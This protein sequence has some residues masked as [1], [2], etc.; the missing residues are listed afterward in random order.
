M[1]GSVIVFIEAYLLLN[2]NHHLSVIG[3]GCDHKPCFFYKS[4]SILSDADSEVGERRSF[5]RSSFTRKLRSVC[6][7]SSK[8]GGFTCVSY[9]SLCYINRMCKEFKILGKTLKCRQFL[10][11]SNTGSSCDL[12]TITNLGFASMQLQAPL[13]V[14]CF[15]NMNR[16]LLKFLLD[17]YVTMSGG[18]FTSP[19]TGPEKQNRQSYSTHVS[20]LPHE[21]RLKGETLSCPQFT[22]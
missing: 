6:S 9:I 3:F 15:G 18:I 1:L 22:C 5:S 21:F 7:K 20:L 8:L 14:C 2:R 11:L 12:N 10:M 13:N 19:E 4:C 17:K 16:S